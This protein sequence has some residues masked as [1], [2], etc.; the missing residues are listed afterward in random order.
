M[1]RKKLCSKNII[2]EKVKSGNNGLTGNKGAVLLR[3]EICDQSFMI[4]N[5]HL[6]S[7]RRKDQQR[8][9]QLGS[10]FEAAFANVVSGRKMGI[11]NHK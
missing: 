4:L 5:C 6:L 9:A 1:T 8:A 7:G 3:F 2:A 10:I 11:E